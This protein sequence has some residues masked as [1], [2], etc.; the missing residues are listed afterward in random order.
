MFLKAFISAG[1][2][3][4]LVLLPACDAVYAVSSKLGITKDETRNLG[5]GMGF[6]ALIDVINKHQA[7]KAQHEEAAR[8]A[9]AYE[10]SAAPSRTGE[11]NYVAVVVPTEDRG[12]GNSRRGRGTRSVMIVD[13]DTGEAVNDTV[14]QVEEDD[15]ENSGSKTIKI[16]NYEAIYVN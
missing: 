4:A 2:C 9:A 12:T 13:R 3:A 14:Y 7:S 16:E 1:L 6:V 11:P 8:K 5:L 10:A 15:L